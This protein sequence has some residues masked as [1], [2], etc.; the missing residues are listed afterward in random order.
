MQ[1]C[2]FGQ[3]PNSPIFQVSISDDKQLFSCPRR[4]ILKRVSS[5]SSVHKADI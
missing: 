3:Q 1:E 2:H 4:R 5:T